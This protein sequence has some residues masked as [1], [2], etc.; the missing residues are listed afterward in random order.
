MP[1]PHATLGCLF[2]AHGHQ[3]GLAVVG[4]MAVPR[5]LSRATAFCW[6][7]WCGWCCPRTLPCP[8]AGVPDITVTDA[9]FETMSAFTATGATALSGLDQLPVS[10][11]VWRCLLQL[12]G[13]L[14]I[15][16]LVVA[17]LPLL[18]WAACSSTR[19]KPQGR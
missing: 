7:T 10:V 19:P 12:I 6:S 14:G 16:L 2:W 8:C 9:Y 4:T 17:V 1:R 15:M 3:R 13:G 11:N 18:G 5:E